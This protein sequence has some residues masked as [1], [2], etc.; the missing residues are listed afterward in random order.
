[1]RFDSHC[2]SCK[3]SLTIVCVYSHIGNFQKKQSFE[4]SDHWPYPIIHDLNLSSQCRACKNKTAVSQLYIPYAAKLLF[5]VSSVC[6]AL[7]LIFMPYQG[8]T[9]HEYCRSI[10]HNVF[11]AN[12][13][14]IAVV[15][16]NTG[17]MHI[18]TCTTTP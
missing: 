5:Q 17:I 3:T 1:M 18:Y 9:K 6:L 15:T 8:T 10:I 7:N 4:V 14:L 2:Q 16:I 13:R 11:R 12:P